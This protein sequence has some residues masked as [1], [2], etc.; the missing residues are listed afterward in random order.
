MMDKSQWL[1]LQK[2]LGPGAR[3]GV[4]ARIFDSNAKL[5]DEV[6]FNADSSFPMASAAKTVIGMM[7]SAN[8]ASG[9]LSLDERIAIPRNLLVPGFAR[10]PIDHL[11]Y[12]PFDTRRIETV[13]RLLAF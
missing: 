12:V 10:S 11:F 5:Q 13:E 8:I 6:E 7:A 4:S 1:E 2:P 9:N 3:L